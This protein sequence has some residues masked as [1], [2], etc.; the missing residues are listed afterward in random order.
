MDMNTDVIHTTG[1]LEDSKHIIDSMRYVVF[2]FVLLEVD[3]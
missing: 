1:D 2:Y 3:I